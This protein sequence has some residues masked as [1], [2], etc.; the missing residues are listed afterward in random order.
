MDCCAWNR[1]EDGVIEIPENGSTFR[2]IEGKWPCF[3]EEPH[4]LRLSLQLTVSI[5]L[6]R[7]DLFTQCVLCLLSTI[8]YL[9]G[10][11]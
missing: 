3:K 9:H 6:E 10:C 8:T 5:H 1:S 2:N 7:S 4:N 11:Q